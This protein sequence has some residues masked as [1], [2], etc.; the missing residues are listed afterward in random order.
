MKERLG[1]VPSEMMEWWIKLY[2]SHSPRVMSEIFDLAWGTEEYSLLPTIN[3]PTLVI[4]SKAK[5]SLDETMEWQKQIRG[6][7]LVV[8]PVT[9][10]GRMI[11]ASKPEACTKALL[12]FLQDLSAKKQLDEV[13]SS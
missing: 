2:S 11:S 8:I 12:D 3:V 7:R 4:D 5:R 10:E 13:K 6:S 9:H 1:E